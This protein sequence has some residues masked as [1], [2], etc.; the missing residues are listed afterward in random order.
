MKKK[1]S[2]SRPIISRKFVDDVR[3]AAR[4]PAERERETQIRKT[5]QTEAV[6]EVSDLLVLRK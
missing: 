4:M 1:R 3:I 5:R 6:M 2:G